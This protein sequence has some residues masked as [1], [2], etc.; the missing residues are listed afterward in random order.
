MLSRSVGN[1]CVWKFNALWTQWLSL[2]KYQKHEKHQFRKQLEM[3]EIHGRTNVF[4]S[5]FNKVATLQPATSFKKL[6]D[7][8]FILWILQIFSKQT[9]QYTCGRLPLQFQL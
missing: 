8:E 5:V 3:H 1:K 2:M 7:T 9:F 4:G 6:P